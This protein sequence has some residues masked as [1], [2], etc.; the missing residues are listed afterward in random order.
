MRSSRKSGSTRWARLGVALFSALVLVGMARAQ[1]SA[2]L[3]SDQLDYPPGAT[4]TLTG[5]GFWA[6]ETVTVQ[7]VHADGDPPSGAQHDPWDVV[8]GPGGGFVTTWTVCEDDCVGELLLATADGETSGLHA[9]TTFWDNAQA[10]LDQARNGSSSGVV[11]PVDFQNG[12]L[13]AQQSHYVEG[14]SAAYRAVMEDLPTGC[15]ITITL[16]YD[17][18]HSGRHAIDYLTHYDRLQPHTYA[19]H[20]TQETVNPLLGVTP[21]SGTTTTIAIPAP[22]SLN[23]P[24]PGQPT[25]SF[26]ALPAGERVMTLFGGTITGIA[27]VTEGDLTASQSETRI[28]VTF[29]VPVA[30]ATAVLAWGGHIASRA[31]WGFDGGGV[32]RSAGGISGSPY[33]M[34]IIGWSAPP[35]CNNDLGNLG[36]Q[37]RSMSAGAVVPPPTCSIGGP[38][39]VCAGST[40]VYTATTDATTPTY[41][42]S[43]INNTSGATI[44][45]SATGSFVSVS[46]GGTGGYEVQV[47]ITASGFTST[48]TYPVTVNLVGGCSITG[49]SPVCPNSQNVYS[50]PGG[51]AS[52]LWSIT[53]DGTIFGSNAGSSVTVD[54][55][56]TCSGS[57]T[58]TLT[59]T[60]FAGCVSTC[61]SPFVVE[62]VAAPAIS[63]LPGPTKIVCPATPSFATPTATDACDPN[64]A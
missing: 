40:N 24:V 12:N 43:L 63:A 27:Y 38:G 34:R 60:T 29:T 20:T 32:P 16:G 30:S 41:L 48:C 46:S 64:P 2:T 28:A 42:W 23:S 54:A 6:G 25:T 33:H 56:S 57:Y 22:N 47:A 5:A 10:N 39:S 4:A 19:T 11:S 21:S 7:V 31:D 17:I 50:G 45:G 52:Y 61:S 1:G 55:G 9:Q 59:V 53:G 37:D 13:G 35:P 58:L 3:T 8:A 14:Q 44:V 36:N 18:K 51:M 49:P 26:N 62:D 15:P